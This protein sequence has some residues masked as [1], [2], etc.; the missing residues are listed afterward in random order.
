VGLGGQRSKVG[1]AARVTSAGPLRNARF[2][3]LPSAR[4]CRRNG[5][6]DQSKVSEPNPNDKLLL[7]IWEQ[8]R[9][10]NHRKCRLVIS[11]VRCDTRGINAGQTTQCPSDGRQA[12]PAPYR[13]S[14]PAPCKAGTVRS[15]STQ[16]QAAES[17]T[18]RCSRKHMQACMHRTPPHHSGVC[19]ASCNCLVTLECCLSG[20]CVT[21]QGRV[22]LDGSQTSTFSKTNGGPR[23][24]LK[25]AHQS[26][27]MTRHI[28]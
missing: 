23:T 2:P 21:S 24:G 11:S 20:T 14:L 13:P 26:L 3:L 28:D 6:L 22:V 10:A 12:H 25:Q 16:R 4:H 8:R 7:V 5:T 27:C 19:C 15:A 17:R 18:N 1:A 9:I